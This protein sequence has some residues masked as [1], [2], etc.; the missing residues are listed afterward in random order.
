MTVEEL[1]AEVV[2]DPTIKPNFTSVDCYAEPNAIFLTGA[3]GFLGAFLLDELLR[4]TQARI[5][6]LVRGCKTDAEAQQKIVKNLDRYL[7]EY[8]SFNSRIIPVIR[9]LS[10][11]LLGLNEQQF[12]QLA[13][14]IDVIYHAATFLNLAYP[15]TAMR[16]ANVWGTQEI[17]RLASKIQLKSVH[18]VSSYAVFKSTGY[19]N[20]TSIL[21]DDDLENCGVVYGGYAQSKWVTEKLLE[22]AISQGIPVSIY[23]P[24]T[25]TGHSQTGAYNTDQ[26]WGC[27]LKSFI[28]QGIAPDLNIEFD[29]TPVDYVSQAIVY[30]SRQQESQGKTFNLV[31]PE[32]LK[33]GELVNLICSLGYPIELID[34]AKWESK[35][36][37]VI[38]SSPDNVLS[39]ILP[40]LTKKISG[41]QLTYLEASSFTS[42]LD[43]ENTMKGLTYTSITC[44]SAD[45]KLLR[46]YLG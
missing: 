14:E 22:T 35:M 44:P 34:Y 10:S 30:L 39:P 21:E 42:K 5:Y 20:K 36:R 1:L 2:L 28:E 32:C 24:G 18:F 26:I 41:T 13:Q 40:F 11:S 3:T 17:L 19:F 33:I 45:S 15:Y 37:D 9:D 29:L 6:C 46:T 23:R 8:D 16:A 31:N 4:Q 7:L 43:C 38:L 25:I 27:L 12:E